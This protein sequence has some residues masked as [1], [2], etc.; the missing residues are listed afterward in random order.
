MSTSPRDL[1]GL[2]EEHAPSVRAGL[3]DEGYAVLLG[4]LRVLAEAPEHDARA[5]RRALQGVRLALLPLPLTHVVREA[6]DG[7]RFASASDPGVLAE[8]G[9]RAGDLLARLAVPETDVSPANSSEAAPRPDPEPGVS[10]DEAAGPGP[11]AAPAAEGPVPDG[12]PDAASEPAPD[13][14]APPGAA[15][16]PPG[17][18]G[19]VPGRR[20]S[21]P[22]TTAEIIAA[23]RRRLLSV[24]ALDRVEL[25][26]RHQD[27]LPEELIGLED[28]AG[29][30]RY[31]A[32]QFAGGAAGSGGPLPVVLRINRLL[33]A[34]VDPWGAAD[35]WLSGNR[36][37]GGPPASF[38]G[39]LSDEVLTGAARA[40]VEGD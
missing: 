12:S 5:T 30:R 26:A 40:L 39:E 24:P 11:A 17:A 19:P 34:D 13:P 28:A 6:L 1:L 4:R 15:A 36:R 31:P 33:L 21:V 23:A 10:S 8:L 9:A 32:F 22:R 35:W 7:T 27:S 2:I 16:G 37:L 18:E 38:L 20:S 29:E 25:G 14:A 3:G